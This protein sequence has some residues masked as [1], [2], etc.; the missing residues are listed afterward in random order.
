MW[1]KFDCEHELH[2][3][4]ERSGEDLHVSIKILAWRKVDDYP[5]GPYD[6]VAAVF[7]TLKYGKPYFNVKCYDEKAT[8][9]LH[10]KKAVDEAKEILHIELD[11]VMNEL[12]S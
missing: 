5:E 12:Y 11:Y 7:A 6:I 8:P 1:Q 3:H 4:E 10:F 9:F 2:Y